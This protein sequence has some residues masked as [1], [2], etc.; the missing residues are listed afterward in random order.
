MTIKC[1][2]PYFFK[3]L[4]M[5]NEDKITYVTEEEA[6]AS[7][8]KIYQGVPIAIYRNIAIV[9]LNK[10]EI[11]VHKTTNDSLPSEQGK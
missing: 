3:E 2:Q 7:A 8:Q 5:E 10:D 4:D 9:G 1:A 6:I 11:I